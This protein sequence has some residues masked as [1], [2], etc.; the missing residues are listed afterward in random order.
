MSS[1]QSSSQPSEVIISSDAEHSIIRIPSVTSSVSSITRKSTI[2]LPIK[3]SPLVQQEEELDDIDSVSLSSIDCRDVSDCSK[4]I[5]YDEQ[6]ITA[7][8][9]E[10]FETVA[11]S[12]VI[13]VD[14]PDDSPRVVKF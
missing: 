4:S 9:S 8:C 13:R 12:H 10:M 14:D 1:V 5:R 6:T 11:L 2:M 3:S 7:D